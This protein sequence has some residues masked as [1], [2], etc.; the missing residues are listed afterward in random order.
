MLVSELISRLQN[1]LDGCGDFPVAVNL[2]KNELA[3]GREVSTVVLENVYRWRGGSG[4]WRKD[5]YPNDEVDKDDEKRLA[6]NI[7]AG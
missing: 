5:D 4:I 1:M 7:S 2:N 3:N 6:V